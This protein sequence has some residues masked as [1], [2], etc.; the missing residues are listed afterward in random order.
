MTDDL[1]AIFVAV[2]RVD[3]DCPIERVADA[4]GKVQ[5]AKEA[6]SELERE[7]KARLL[8]RVLA[9]GPFV[10]GETRYWASS[11]STTKCVDVRDA[12]ETVLQ[13]NGGDFDVLKGCLASDAMKPGACKK[14]LSPEL[15]ARCFRVETKTVLKTGLVAPK[16]L[17]SGNV[18]YLPGAKAKAAEVT[19]D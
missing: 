8:A 17:Q 10:L 19:H 18:N 6:I 13:H 4:L 1:N 9:S 3:S 7:L 2:A 15:W 12:V 5:Y 11:P 16:E 14:V